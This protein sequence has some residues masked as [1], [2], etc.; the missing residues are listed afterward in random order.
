MKTIT[1]LLSSA[2]AISALVGPSS[3]AH[4]TTPV[5]PDQRAS[6]LI[7][8]ADDFIVD[9]YHN[10]V[11]VPDRDRELVIERFGATAER[12]T[13]DVRK[14][15]WLVFNVVNNRLRWGGC[16]YF[17]VAGSLAP[18]ELGFV[19]E[20]ESGNWSVCDDPGQT[21]HFIQERAFMRHNRAV[22]IERPWGEGTMFMQQ[23]AGTTWDG[24]PLWGRKRNTWIKVIVD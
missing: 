17:A 2:L 11:L 24:T 8:V 3:L 20:L 18:N 22:A 4:R 14:G 23:L 16:S 12:I 6:H 10:G 19:S 7:T 21:H 15:D 1:T 9:V 13:A 5:A